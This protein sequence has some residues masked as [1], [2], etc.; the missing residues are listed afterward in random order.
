MQELNPTHF[1]DRLDETLRRYLAT[2]LPISP[3]YPRLRAEFAR[4][5]EREILVRGPYVESLPDFEKGE[6]LRGLLKE[7]VLQSSWLRLTPDL[8]D[9]PLH[10]PQERALRLALQDQASFVVATGTGSGKTEC[11]LLPGIDRLLRDPE[12]ASPGCGSS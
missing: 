9:R 7:G 5:L 1:R 10:R 11:F 6:T 3:R 12:R 8:L 4:L 2:A